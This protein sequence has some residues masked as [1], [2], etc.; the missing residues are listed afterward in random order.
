M[1]G[2]ELLSD[3]SLAIMSPELIAD[4]KWQNYTGTVWTMVDNQCQV[5]K[6]QNARMASRWDYVSYSILCTAPLAIKIE[7]QTLTQLR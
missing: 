4:D 5:Y 6:R 1:H 7:V 2:R 3:V